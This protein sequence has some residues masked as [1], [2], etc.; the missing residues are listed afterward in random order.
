MLNDPPP[1]HYPALLYAERVQAN[2][3]LRLYVDSLGGAV[4]ESTRVEE[5]SNYPALDSAA[6]AGSRELR[7]SPARR[8]G[9]R[10]GASVLFPV[11]FRHPDA[12]P[13]PGDSAMPSAAPATQPTP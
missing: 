7:F 9:R 3:T 8:D 1:F 4:P 13:L 10:V 6:I 2:V 12:A 11:Y 5:T